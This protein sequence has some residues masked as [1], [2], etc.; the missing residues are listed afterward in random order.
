MKKYDVPLDLSPDSISGKIINQIERGAAVLEFGCSYGRMTQYISQELHCNV[1]I[2]ELDEEAYPVALRYAEDGFCGD[3][4]QDGWYLH[5][6]RCQF[7]YIIF[8]DVLEHLRDPQKALERAKTLLKAD[9]KVLISLPNIGHNDILVN[10]FHNKFEYTPTGLLDNTHIH[11]WGKEDLETFS[12]KAGFG[13]QVLDGVYQ[14]PFYTE[15]KPDKA[16]T[17]PNLLD[18]LVRREYN[19][20]Y[21]FFLVLQKTEWIAQHGTKCIDKLQKFY[22]EPTVFCYWDL[23]YGYQSDLYSRLIPELMPNGKFRFY[24]DSIPSGCQK[25]RFDP[26]LGYHCLV[27]DIH[28]LTNICSCD[29]TALNGVCVND[30]TVFFNANPQMEFSLPQGA[31]WFEITAFIHIGFGDEFEEIVSALQAQQS[32]HKQLDQILQ[33]NTALQ[34][35]IEE[36]SARCEVFQA[37]SVWKDKKIK[38]LEQRISQLEQDPSL[39]LKETHITN[40]EAIIANLQAD[41]TELGAHYQSVVNSRCW[42]LTKPLR[43][44]LDG[45]KRLL[46][47]RGSATDQ[48][49][50]VPLEP[51][52]NI[53]EDSDLLPKTLSEMANQVISSGGQV[54]HQELFLSFD[55]AAKK[56]VLL[57]SHQL[58]LTGAPVALSYLAEALREQ[59]YFPVIIAPSFDALGERLVQDEFPVLVY[60]SVLDSDLVQRYA[61]VF[62]AVVVCTIVGA[63]IVS[64]LN[65]SAVPVLWW[66]HEAF[67]SYHHDSL[68][69]MPEALEDNIHVYCGGH[70]AEQVL[71]HHFPN[72]QAKQLLYYVPDYATELPAEPTFRL[73]YAE[74]KRVFAIVGMQEE[75][76]GQDILVQAIRNLS[77]EVRN[78]CLF[79]FVGKPF[80]PPIL[81]DIFSICE[82]YPRNACYIE[83]LDRDGL[84]SLYMQIDCLIC[85]SRDDPMPIVVTEAMLMSKAIICSENT[86]SADI[87]AKMDSGLIYYNNDP[88]ELAHCITTV[89]LQSDAEL[90]P[91]CQ[92]ARQSY[93]GFFTQD[94]FDQSV[95]DIFDD[96]IAPAKA[97]DV[98]PG[99][100]SVVIPTFNAGESFSTLL[101]RLQSQEGVG[102]IE[103][104]VVDS[105]SHDGTPEQAEQKGA[106]VIRISQAE[107]SHSYARNLGA[108]NASGDYLLFMTQDAMPIGS[109]WVCGLMQPVLH[110]G[111]VAVSCQEKP[112]PD[113]DLL[114][115]ISIWIHSEYM[116]ILEADRIMRLPNRQDCDSIRKNG[117]LNDVTCLIQ[118]EIFLQFKYRGDYAEDLDLGIRLI[119]AGYNLALLSSVQVLHSHTRPALYHMKRA[120]VDLNTLKKILPDLP[121]EQITAQTLANRSVTAL[122]A[123]ILYM[124]KAQ[125][126][127]KDESW[128]EFCQWS[129]TCFSQIDSSLAQMSREELLSL[130]QVDGGIVDEALQSFAIP[131]LQTY[132]D[133]FTLDTSYCRSWQFFM[134]DTVSRYFAAHCISYTPE[135]HEKILDLLPK[136]TAQLFGILLAAYSMTAAEKDELLQKM[137]D[138]YSRGV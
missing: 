1:C 113:C 107:F 23:G 131:L 67:T 7:D 70:Y 65:G 53:L 128:N 34:D 42:K 17:S 14:R 32:L 93:E 115:K 68:A 10:L 12:Q 74:G 36:F 126:R 118:R 41:Y 69:A 73:K 111:V 85:A 99:K 57:F 40:L 46:P 51:A 31:Q 80:F 112:R 133:N 5:F 6:S 125:N 39:S 77:P 127:D 59:G 52:E 121:V 94:V 122:C 44:I 104:V 114:G 71:T 47:H 103:I 29:V 132:W 78:Q 88:E 13:I 98:Y 116:G 108:Q 138:Q 27:R 95:K 55:I 76:K 43:L 124:K 54:F 79:V 81:K 26:P 89:A 75:R 87:L 63:P 28:V 102:A 83:E 117:Q 97:L 96:L 110:S 90:L 105:G 16:S 120:L 58:N 100:V 84:T 33:D 4:D 2:V 45:A 135:I 21:Q 136:Y 62:D 106:K 11:F 19:E 50:D 49:S 15:Q 9:G 66:I 130:L 72:Y 137:I 101:N 35:Q 30:V 92:R 48:E 82:D 3:I 56:K 64:S 86:G 22:S 60:E 109:Q 37:H 91:M 123:L 8:A 61:A 20:V 25:V 38:D 119:Q 24:C 18:A 134:T 129:S